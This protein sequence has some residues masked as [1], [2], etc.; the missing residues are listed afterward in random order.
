MGGLR[1]IKR[2]LLANNVNNSI[3]ICLFQHNIVVEI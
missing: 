3:K 2:F 1:W